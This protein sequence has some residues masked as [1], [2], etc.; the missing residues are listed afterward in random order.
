MDPLAAAAALSNGALTVTLSNG[1]TVSLGKE[2]V[3]F[4]KELT[5]M[6]EAVETIQVGEILIAISQ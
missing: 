2:Y 3:E 4:E 6:G 1:E 5:L